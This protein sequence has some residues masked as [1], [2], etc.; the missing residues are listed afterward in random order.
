MM[1]RMAA[2][3]HDN[4]TPMVLFAYVPSVLVFTD[5]ITEEFSVSCI[6][7]QTVVTN[8]AG[9]I[10]CFIRGCLDWQGLSPVFA[11]NMVSGWS[12]SQ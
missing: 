6:Y 5:F 2:V 7:P 4:L 8:A 9:R 3:G 12:Y 1:G 11:G 10:V